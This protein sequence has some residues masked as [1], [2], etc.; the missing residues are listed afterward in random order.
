[1][2]LQWNQKDERTRIW[3]IR[4]DEIDTQDLLG[5]EPKEVLPPGSELDWPT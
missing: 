3:K 4:S 5:L 2:Y 1:L